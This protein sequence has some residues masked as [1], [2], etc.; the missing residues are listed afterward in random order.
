MSKRRRN[1]MA[2]RSVVEKYQRPAGSNDYSPP[3]IFKLDMD[4]F[5]ESLDFLCLNEL[6]A[7]G[8]TCKQLNQ[9]AGYIFQLHYPDAIAVLG[10]K[11]LY[12]GGIQVNSFIPYI[13]NIAMSYVT[14]D[15]VK[16]V[17]SHRF[18]SLEHLQ[19]ARADLS[20][21]LME[22]MKAT[23]ANLETVELVHCT[24]S[25]D[26]FEDILRFCVNIKRLV[27]VGHRHRI[28]TWLL[29][30][31]PSLEH[32]ELDLISEQ[33]V[34]AL[35]VFFDQNSSVKKVSLSQRTLWMNKT[36]ISATNA[37]VE[38][39]EIC[40]I[41]GTMDDQ[42]A[43]WNF[44]KELRDRGFYQQLHMRCDGYINSIHVSQNVPWNT[45]EKLHVRFNSSFLNNIGIMPSLTNLNELHIDSNSN[46]LSESSA[47]AVA[48]S[49]VQLERIH[50]CAASPMLIHPFIRHTRKLKTIHIAKLRT[51]KQNGICVDG[52]IVKEWNKVRG[53]L[54]EARKVT[55]YI[56]E[57]MYLDIKWTLNE[58]DFGLIKTRRYPSYINVLN[59]VLNSRS[60]PII[61]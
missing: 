29:Q 56:E 36:A 42:D 47:N 51:E 33:P 6:V 43:F 54:A 12:I 9:I 13:R 31:Y 28:D 38:V 50:L 15:D 10:N 21:S 34:D 1:G 40:K 37:K 27:I 4:C 46:L 17:A 20:A 52:K 48:K 60:Y 26:L 8:Q 35:K 55:I 59:R 22:G 23:L 3:D 30:K 49:L 41:A 2:T 19:L 24:F 5:G 45:L 39:L 11:I 25:T 7:V 57:E 18:D 53:L 61:K 16:F 58:T 44:V 14:S 32:C